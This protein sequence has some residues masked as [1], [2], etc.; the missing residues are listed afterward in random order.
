MSMHYLFLNLEFEVREEKLKQLKANL[1]KDRDAAAMDCEDLDCHKLSGET[2][3]VALTSIPALSVR[4]L[5]RLRRAE[6]LSEENL[7]LIE[8]FLKDAPENPVLVLDAAKWDAKSDLKKSIRARMNVMAGAKEEPAETVFTM[9][10]ELSNG[11]TVEALRILHEI[12]SDGE[13]PEMLIGGMVWK[14]SNHVKGRVS[15]ERYK[16]GLLVL[17]EADRDV[18]HSRFPRREQAVEKA[19]V[20]LSSLLKV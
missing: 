12:T 1:F 19:L 14:W 18:K 10:D 4:K 8:K 15:A 16:K 7:G 20:K 6:K 11:R 2:L 13:A 9:M 3:K 17:Q 5:V